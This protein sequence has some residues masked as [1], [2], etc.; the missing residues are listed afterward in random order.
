MTRRLDRDVSPH[1]E[2]EKKPIDLYSLYSKIITIQSS[3]LNLTYT[4]RL[5]FIP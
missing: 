5:L 3:L 2:E 1:L 4:T